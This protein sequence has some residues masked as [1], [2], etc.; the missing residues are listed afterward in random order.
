MFLRLITNNNTPL[1]CS[2]R[3]NAINGENDGALISFEFHLLGQHSPADD[4]RNSGKKE[5]RVETIHW[6]ACVIR[7]TTAIPLSA[8]MRISE[9]PG[10]L[11]IP[12]QML[13]P[14]C[15]L[16]FVILSLESNPI[17]YARVLQKL[18]YLSQTLSISRV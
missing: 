16:R 7:E 13:F 10:S 1:I 11:P 2:L 14:N 15:P 5:R 18:P 17:H 9:Y 8:R 3:I 4:S 12:P 6:L